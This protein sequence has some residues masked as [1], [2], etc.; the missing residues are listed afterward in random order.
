MIGMRL[1]LYNLD[2]NWKYIKDRS[3]N[4]LPLNCKLV[5][6]A[7]MKQ[8]WSITKHQ[9]KLISGFIFEDSFYHLNERRY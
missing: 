6:W 9:Y 8:L 5:Y 1:K 7:W 2:T 3:K 4:Y